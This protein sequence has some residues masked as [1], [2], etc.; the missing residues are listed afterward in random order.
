MSE[1][2]DSVA[3]TMDHRFDVAYLEALDAQ[4]AEGPG[5]PAVLGPLT[6]SVLD[7]TKARIRY[8]APIATTAIAITGVVSL[9]AASKVIAKKLT[10]KI[11]AKIVAKGSAKMATTLGGGRS[12]GTPMFME[13]PWCSCLRRRGWWLRP[14]WQLT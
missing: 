13:W 6:R 4:L 1:R 3:N 14:G 12:R 5:S 2:L 7:D 8:T 10:T 11:F 9:K